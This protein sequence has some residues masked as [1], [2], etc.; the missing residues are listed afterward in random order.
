M[1][2]G[3]LDGAIVYCGVSRLTGTCWAGETT[4]SW[5]IYKG[6]WSGIK[7]PRGFR[8]V[9]QDPGRTGAAGAYDGMS[10]VSPDGVREFYIYAPQCSGGRRWIALRAGAAG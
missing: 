4:A 9:P 8:V 5:P 6:A 1:A 10:F 3:R 2:D 7:C